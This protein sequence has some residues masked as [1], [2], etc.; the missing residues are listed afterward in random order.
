MAP[1]PVRPKWGLEGRLRGSRSLIFSLRPKRIRGRGR[2]RLGASERLRGRRNERS[3]TRF[4]SIS[5]P[6]TSFSFF[7]RNRT[8]ARPPRPLLLPGQGQN[9]D[10]VSYNKLELMGLEPWAKFSCPFVGATK[11]PKSALNFTP[12]PPVP[13]R[14]PLWIS[15]DED[16]EHEEES[17]ISEFRLNSVPVPP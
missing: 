7:N 16:D 13:Y 10:E 2:G 15:E 5:L 6:R 11:H 3:S 9:L 12:F 4:S 17:P 14:C 1:L 8:R